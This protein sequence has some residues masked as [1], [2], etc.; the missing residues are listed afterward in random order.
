MT[1][2]LASRITEASDCPQ[3]AS[4]VP[5]EWLGGLRAFPGRTRQCSRI[6]KYRLDGKAICTEHLGPIA[7]QLI[8]ERAAYRAVPQPSGSAAEAQVSVPM[9]LLGLKL[10]LEKS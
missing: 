9:S 4:K 3:C 10:Q 2:F 5:D 8:V 6:A 7:I 1:V